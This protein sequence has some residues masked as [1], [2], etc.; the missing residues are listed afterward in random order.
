M[1]RRRL[2]AGIVVVVAV[3]VAALLM[4]R[5]GGRFDDAFDDEAA[6]Q[7]GWRFVGGSATVRADGDRS[8]LR[9][10]SEAA[11]RS[12]VAL[13]DG[14]RLYRVDGLRIKA[15]VHVASGRG[16]IAWGIRDASGLVAYRLEI[17]SGRNEMIL[18]ERHPEGLEYAIVTY[19]DPRLA[20]RNWWRLAI[21]STDEQFVVLATTGGRQPEEIMRDSQDHEHPGL[22]T[23]EQGNVGLY[24]LGGTTWFDDVAIQ[25]TPVGAGEEETGE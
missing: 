20:P 18:Y 8:A 1:W 17:D 25:G 15:T 3:A 5:T 7:S 23:F 4:G 13:A 19:R 24:A 2:L 21:A 11:D 14:G 12:A 16:G 9:L 10:E 22:Q 6:T